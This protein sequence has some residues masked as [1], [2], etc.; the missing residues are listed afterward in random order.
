MNIDIILY[1][2]LGMIFWDFSAHV[3][4][5]F[6]WDSK[7]VRSKSVFSYYYPHLSVKKTVSGPVQ[8]PHWQNLY[9]RFWVGFWGTGFVLLFIYRILR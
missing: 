7:F 9:Q 3:I 5:L 6:K 1:I 4:E 2:V 8:R